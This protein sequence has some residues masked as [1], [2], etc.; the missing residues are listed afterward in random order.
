MSGLETAFLVAGIA[1]AAATTAVTIKGAVDGK[2]KRPGAPSIGNAAFAANAIEL[3]RQ[4]K[5][6][7]RASTVKSGKLTQ[8]TLGAPSLTPGTKQTLGG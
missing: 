5:R 6:R 7:G 4:R 2:G 3:E 8:P 1:S